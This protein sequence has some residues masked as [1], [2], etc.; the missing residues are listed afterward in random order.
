MDNPFNYSFLAFDPSTSVVSPSTTNLSKKYGS[1]F[2][3]N[4]WASSFMPT[5]KGP[6]TATT[7]GISPSSASPSTGT[8]PG[9]SPTSDS[10][11]P[12]AGISQT[13]KDQYSLWKMLQ[14]D[15]QA[16]R[17]SE[18][19]QQANLTRQQMSD[20]FPYMSAAAS[21]ATARNLAASKQFLAFKEGT[22]SNIQNI[23]ASKQGQASSAADAEYRR[24]LGIAAQQQAATD[25]ARKFAGQTF[26]QA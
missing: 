19:Q 4:A 20:L 5:Q 18:Y 7:P 10:P 22:P 12:M 9:T 21:E 13:V 17:A 2:D 25:F 11:V 16:Q 6:Y 26:Q 1:G 23:M 8:T 3:P 24:A 15:L 14:P